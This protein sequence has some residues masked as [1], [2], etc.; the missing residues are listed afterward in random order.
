MQVAALR[1]RT[2][3]PLVMPYVALSGSARSMSKV[4]WSLH[5]LR[6]ALSVLMLAAFAFALREL[7]LANAYAIFWSRHFW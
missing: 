5:L 3:L 7:P 2:T 4:R 6:G 1:G